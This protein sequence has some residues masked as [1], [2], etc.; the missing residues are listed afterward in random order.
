MNAPVQTRLK[1]LFDGTDVTEEVGSDLLSFSY[2]DRETDEADTVTFTLM[3]PDGKWAGSWRPDGGEKVEAAIYD[4]TVHGITG[5]LDC[6]TFTVD[7]LR[8]SGSPRVMEISATSIPLASP[9]RRKKQTRAWEKTTLK[10]IAGAIAGENGLELLWDVE[11]DP[12][13]PDQVKQD[14][15]SDLE[16]LLGLCRDA[17]ASVKVT[18]GKLVVFDQRAYEKK[19]PVGTFV[20]GTSNVISWEFSTQKAETY[21]SVKVSWRSPKQKSKVTAASYYNRDFEKVT[22]KPK[23]S[24]GNPAVNEYVYTDPDAPEDGQE[25]ELKKKCSS[26]AE[27][28]R[29]AKAKL[30]ELNARSV[31]GRITVVGDTLL[32]AGA[33]VAVAGFGA[34][35]GNFIIEGAKHSVGREGYA[36]SLELRRV[37]GRY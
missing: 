34:W 37:N 10:A 12:E 13:Y 19:E 8:C 36:T 25:F 1:V 15:A 24:G 23:K 35:D 5:V 32:V 27:A 14:K 18:D 33:V 17:G 6:G 29:L 16:F 7:S 9:I 22:V 28:E 21:R 2:S 11:D 26:R 4:G 3:D 31:T 20:L 30:R